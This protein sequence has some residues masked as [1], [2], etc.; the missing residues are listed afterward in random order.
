MSVNET[1]IYNKRCRLPYTDINADI[2]IRYTEDIEYYC[3]LDSDEPLN[4]V[5]Y[6]L[7]FLVDTG[8]DS[9]RRKW[10]YR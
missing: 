8:N 7:Q 4:D 5:H 1:G 6:R 2:Y 3:I 9:I 10:K